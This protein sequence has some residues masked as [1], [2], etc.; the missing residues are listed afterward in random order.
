M[1]PLVEWSA[2]RQLAFGLAGYLA[3]ALLMILALGSPMKVEQQPDA[4]QQTT[5]ETVADDGGAGKGRLLEAEAESAVFGQGSYADIV[6]HR[7]AN[8]LDESWWLVWLALTETVPLMLLGMALYRLGFF[9]GLFDARR[10]K[11]WGWV[12]FGGGALATLA[13]G[14]VA[15]V[16]R[17]PAV[18]YHLRGQRHRG[19]CHL[20]TMLGLLALLTL[21]G[22]R[23]AGGWLG[24]RL[25]AAGGWRFTTISALRCC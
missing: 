11:L 4:P 22:L 21:Q 5:Q 2:R 16:R 14:L 24:S 9:S 25:V 3:G 13:I 19:A 23:S 18:P 8:E 1:L 17:L 12:G 7:A 20:P 10:M 15:V 6:R